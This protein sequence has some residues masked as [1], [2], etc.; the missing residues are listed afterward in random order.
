MSIFDQSVF[1]GDPA[2]AGSNRRVVKVEEAAPRWREL[3]DGRPIA[4]G[5]A[6]RD[7]VKLLQRLLVCL[8]FTTSKSQGFGDGSALIDGDFGGGTERGLRQFQAENGLDPS[9]RLDPPDVRRLEAKSS[10]HVESL[11]DDEQDRLREVLD[12]TT[13][14]AISE[15]KLNFRESVLFAAAAADV[16]EAV[17]AAITWVES[18]G[19]SRN[20]P[21][22][23]S[24]HN[25]ALLDIAAAL[26]DV[27]IAATDAAELVELR[28]KVETI[29]IRPGDNGSK[30]LLSR[31]LPAAMAGQSTPKTLRRA[32]LTIQSWNTTDCRVLATSWGW[33]QTMGW[34]TLSA[35]MRK[36]DI[37]L[38]DLRSYDP[39]RQIFTLGRTIAASRSWKS[40]ARRSQKESDFSYFAES[41]NGVK[42]GTPK[43]EAYATQML[44]AVEEYR[45]A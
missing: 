42:R 25:V 11:P 14:L 15:F 5:E 39:A 19:G 7:A 8:G 22:F 34:H 32:L 3:L 13:S 28:H 4:R 16:E 31:T 9:G 18:N 36:A 35:R 38:G 1:T 44:A 26:E 30:T 23:E 45:N 43:N 27:E 6:N 21:K 12:R 2:L 10:A 17:I 41:Y 24:H 20:L 33:G 37:T 40:A 29:P